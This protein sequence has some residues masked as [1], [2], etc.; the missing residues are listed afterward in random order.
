MKKVLVID[1]DPDILEAI[2]MILSGED[3]DSEAIVKGA[4]TYTKVEQYMPDLIILD[5][6]LPDCDGLAVLAILRQGGQIPIIVL[7]ARSQQTEKLS[8][9][10]L[11]ADDYITKPFDM[12]EL[13]ARIR[14]VL[15]RARPSVSRIRLGDVT[16]DFL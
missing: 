15:R 4:E 5:I 13:L 16:I 3:Y 10:R 7:T 1:D 2:Q 8:G 12:E 11:G 9:L 14:A 6:T